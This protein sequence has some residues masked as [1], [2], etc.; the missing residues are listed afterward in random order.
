M[1]VILIIFILGSWD[2]SPRT[3]Q[4]EFSSMDRCRDAVLVIREN[5]GDFRNRGIYIILSCVR[6]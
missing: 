2:G 3:E 5:A 4:V 1:K 6:K